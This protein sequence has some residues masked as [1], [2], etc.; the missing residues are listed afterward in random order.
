MGPNLGVFFFYRRC[1]DSLIFSFLFFFFF[2]F[3]VSESPLI[4]WK[5]AHT[6]LIWSNALR[7]KSSSHE[8]EL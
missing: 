4:S 5:I 8:G 2:F 6:V 7:A 3:F 1:R